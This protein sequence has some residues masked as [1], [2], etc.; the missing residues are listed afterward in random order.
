[1]RVKGFGAQADV[2]ADLEFLSTFDFH[3]FKIEK[4]LGVKFEAVVQKGGTVEANTTNLNPEDTWD[5]KEYGPLS[6][7]SPGQDKSS[8]LHFLVK[9][10]R[11]GQLKDE[12]MLV[13]VTDEENTSRSIKVHESHTAILITDHFYVVH[14]AKI[15]EGVGVVD[16]WSMLALAP[17]SYT[18]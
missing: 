3:N 13:D 5:V 11:M 15:I 12:M 8:N 14:R 17:N 7:I 4:G 1:M 2:I 6:D 18:W 10:V 16:G 9:V